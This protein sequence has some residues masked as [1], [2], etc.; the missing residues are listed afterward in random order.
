[1]EASGSSNADPYPSG[2]FLGWLGAMDL[3][4][5]NFE[6][7]IAL[8]SLIFLIICSALISSSEVAF[9]SLSPKDF[10]T[11]K[12]KNNLKL[13]EVIDSLVLRPRYLLSTILIL[14][15]LFNVAITI[16]SY[17]A[18]K[19]IF[20][21]HPF[22]GLLFNIVA[23]TLFIVVFGEALP[24]TYAAK[25]P[26]RVMHFLAYPLIFFRTVFHP[27]NYLL[28]NS[29]SFIEKKMK[30]LSKSNV[31]IDELHE[32]IELTGDK[33]NGED[34]MNMLKGIVNFNNTSVK[35]VMRARVD[36]FAVEQ[37]LSFQDLIKKVIEAGYSRIPVYENSMDNIVG[38]L[39][40]KDLLGNLHDSN[41]EWQKLLRPPYYV[42]VSKKINELLKDI[43]SNRNHLSIV[44]DEYGGVSGIITLEDILEEVIGDIND[45]H[46]EIGKEANYK[47]ISKG[48]FII[49]GRT[50]LK[51]FSEIIGKED[52]FFEDVKGD[53]D[54]IAGLFL[55]LWGKFPERNDELQYKHF[56]LK[57]LNIQKNRIDKIKII[58]LNLVKKIK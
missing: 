28:V 5:P 1:M 55:E 49:E 43:Q 8:C 50:T 54:T 27:I 32:A 25:H 2:V 52:T 57:V 36:V 10:R 19:H 17:F 47:I 23:V 3:N 45:E 48:I 53:N 35:Q 42:P 18:I 34:E 38:I 39:Y 15:N 51:E 14:N 44:V 20:Q 16:I 41:F 30:K 26:L 22:V 37:S 7:G 24:K 46:D 31:S 58:D 9:F 4:L 6:V 21:N 33:S 29:T 12:N 40:A 13:H 11:S 56:L